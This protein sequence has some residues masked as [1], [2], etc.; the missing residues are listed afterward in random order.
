MVVVCMHVAAA[1]A[2]EAYLLTEAS[3]QRW[4]VLHASRIWMQICIHCDAHRVLQHDSC[5]APILS[6]FVSAA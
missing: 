3:S 4:S 5:N 2:S 1:A 6:S